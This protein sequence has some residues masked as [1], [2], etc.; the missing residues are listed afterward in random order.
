[1]F[2]LK[3]LEVNGQIFPKGHAVVFSTYATH[4]DP[5]I[6]DDPHQFQPHRWTEK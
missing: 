1:M 5:E 6:F 2:N 3:D 4:R